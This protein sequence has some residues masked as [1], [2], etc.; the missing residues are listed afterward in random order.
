MKR[1]LYFCTRYNTIPVFFLAVLAGI[2][3]T[4][5]FTMLSDPLF[6]IIRTYSTLMTA[7]FIILLVFYTKINR[8]VSFTIFIIATCL[9]TLIEG[10]TT[11]YVCGSEF[12]LFS[13]ISFVYLFTTDID[14]PK[15]YLPVMNLLLLSELAFITYIKI[16]NLPPEGLFI[17]DRRMY[18]QFSEFF[19]IA[20]CIILMVYAGC[21]ATVTLHHLNAK[22]HFFQ[23]EMD[24]TAKHD[25]LTSLMNRIRTTDVLKRCQFMKE[26][27]GIDYG[28]CIFDID[29]FKKI[30]DTYGHDAGDFVLKTYAKEVWDAMGEPKKVARWGG[31]EFLIIFPT[32]NENTIYELDYMRKDLAS[33]PI[34]FKGNDIP[35]S[36]TYGISSSRVIEGTDA[37]LNDADKMLLIGKNNG[38]NRVVVSPNF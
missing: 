13:G 19:C 36:A 35:V 17:P 8:L 11:G 30:N 21:I 26:Q 16:S 20:F 9:Y 28:I 6:A 24:Y 10:M 38:K 14:R 27:H 34:H 12:F 32:I 31:E 22:S 4:L 3:H 1:F 29:N 5:F 37:V 7:T 15:L 23:S 18:F 25:P 2:V 33:K